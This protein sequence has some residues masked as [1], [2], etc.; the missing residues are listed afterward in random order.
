MW[1]FFFGLWHSLEDIM[2]TSNAQTTDRTYAEFK[3]DK[4]RTFAELFSSSSSSESETDAPTAAKPSSFL[5]YK[6]PSQKPYKSKSSELGACQQW[7]RYCNWWEELKQSGAIFIG[8]LL[9]PEVFDDFPESG[10]HIVMDELMFRVTHLQRAHLLSLYIKQLSPLKEGLTHYDGGTIKGYIDSIV[11]RLHVEENKTRKLSLYYGNWS[12][13]NN[14]AYA[15]LFETLERKVHE[16]DVRYRGL[17]KKNPKTSD[18]ITPSSFKKMMLRTKAKREE[19]RVNN[20]LHNFVKMNATLCVH[21]HTYFCGCR[22]QQEIAAIIV[23]DFTDVSPN[24]IKFEQSSDFK[25][26]KLGANFNFIDREASF[27]LG[28]EYCEPFR[29]FLYKRPADA[30]DRF[31]LYDAPTARFQDSIWLAAAKPIGPKPLSK[32]V[33]NE[34]SSMISEGIVADGIYT[35][36]SLRKGLSDR[37]GIAHVPPVLIDLA[38][39]HFNSKSDQSSSAFTSTPNLP[40]YLS[41]WKQSLTRKK[42]ALLLFDP[43]L[44]WNDIENEDHFHQA[45]RNFFPGDFPP[46]IRTTIDRFQVDENSG[47]LSDDLTTQEPIFRQE[48]LPTYIDDSIPDEFFLDFLTPPALICEP[49]SQ[50]QA[51]HFEQKNNAFTFSTNAAPI[52]HIHGGTVNISFAS[53]PPTMPLP[54]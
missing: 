13:K 45:Y 18:S 52:L 46:A 6:P 53:A 51:Q 39:G 19:Y 5:L 12:W 23:Q 34:I 27:I 41:I 3:A 20:D 43:Y 54:K 10:M 40:T 21:I 47:T 36:T 15:F 17:K 28:E 33:G 7:N 29:I 44:T 14:K 30:I 32:A 22:A 35:N 26:R 31:F 4:K 9:D 8:G 11:R 1:I 2:Q 48:N 42:I 16:E 25:T 24:C 38:I 37:L 50:P 49:K